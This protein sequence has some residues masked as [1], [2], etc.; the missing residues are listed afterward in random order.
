MSEADFRYFATPRRVVWLAED[1]ADELEQFE[2]VAPGALERWVRGAREVEGG[3]A[4]GWRIA[5]PSGRAVHLREMAHGGLLRGLTGRRFLS[6]ERARSSLAA[7]ERL[8]SRGIPV[9]APVAMHA[10]RRGP[11]WQIAL[12]NEFIDGAVACGHYLEAE[13][14]G[15]RVDALAHTA[16]RSLLAFHEAGGSHPDLHVDNLLVCQ[17]AALRIVDLDGV[18]VGNGPTPPR[19]RRTEIRR[20]LR[21]LRRRRLPTGDRFGTALVEACAGSA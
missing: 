19:R 17:G 5:L 10:E 3:R 2:L 12:A 7:A 18:T 6:L 8:R 13:Q 20:L 1:W 16:A 4:R 9:P 14:D 21:S 15:T 11:F